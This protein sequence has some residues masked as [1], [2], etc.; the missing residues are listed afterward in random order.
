M[1]SLL[2]AEHGVRPPVP[3]PQ[4]SPARMPPYMVPASFFTKMLGEC[5]EDA[6]RI[7]KALKSLGVLRGCSEKAPRML[8]ECSE[9]APRTA[10]SE[11]ARRM[12]R[13]CSEDAPRM[14]G[15]DPRESSENGMLRKCSENAPKM[16]TD[17][18]LCTLLYTYVDLCRV[19]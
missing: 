13:G 15:K 4:P 8:R 16:Y 11:N 5:S 10:Y 6:P 9:K 12:L 19:M 14:L 17:P 1:A 18:Q 3:Y 7:E 2:A